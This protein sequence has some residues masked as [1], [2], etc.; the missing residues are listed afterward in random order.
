MFTTKNC[1]CVCTCRHTH[2]C[3]HFF[4]VCVCLFTREWGS[5]SV[6]ERGFMQEKITG[7][8]L[9]VAEGLPGEQEGRSIPGSEGT[10]ARRAGHSGHHETLG[11]AGARGLGKGK[12]KV[13]VGPCR[14]P[15]ADAGENVEPRLSSSPCY[16]FRPLDPRCHP[17][18][19][20]L[21]SPAWANLTHTV[22]PNRFTPEGGESQFTCQ[23]AGEKRDLL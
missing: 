3:M 7:L 20:N 6:G 10:E 13:K 4:A 19:C 17:Y 16:P 21:L 23:Q 18:Q 5:R 1:V 22:K 9:R 14:E 12:V 15:S 8:S 2:E 11:E